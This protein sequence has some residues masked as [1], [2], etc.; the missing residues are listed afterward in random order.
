M[1][2]EKEVMKMRESDERV[3]RG[4]ESAFVRPF[5]RRRCAGTTLTGSSAVWWR[6]CELRVEGVNLRSRVGERGCDA[7]GRVWRGVGVTRWSLR[8]GVAATCDAGSS[9]AGCSGHAGLRRGASSSIGRP[10]GVSWMRK[11][12]A[13]CSKGRSFGSVAKF[14]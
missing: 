13:C 7:S 5:A 10:F 9:I 2:S 1:R 8:A 11:R 3:A 12:C 6:R 4:G 14:F